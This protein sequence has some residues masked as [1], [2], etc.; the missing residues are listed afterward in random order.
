[1]PRVEGLLDE[2]RRLEREVAELRRKLAT[3]EVAA[4]EGFKEVGGVR[5][6]G[7]QLEGVAAKELRSTADVIRKQLG[8]GVVALVAVNDGKAAVVVS[9]S[10]DLAGRLDAVELLRRGVA[11]DR[12][13][14]RRRAARF[15][16]RRRARRQPRR[17]GPGGDR[18]RPRRLS[19]RRAGTLSPAPD[20]AG[21]GRPARTSSR[22]TWRV[23]SV[24]FP[25]SEKLTV[26]LA[27]SADCT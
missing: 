12:R 24:T 8:S 3:G 15:R 9:V 11:A 18:G 19:R 23:S 14:G 13:G 1:M 7:R 5:F 16:P 26:T 10:E 22:R 4:G 21:R 20:P 25:C 17:R 2:R 6:A 27:P